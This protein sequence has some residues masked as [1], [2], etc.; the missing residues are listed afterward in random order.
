[1]KKSKVL[2]IGGGFAGCASAHL[3]GMKDDFDV[4][5]IELSPV[6]GA[7]VR[8]YF[9]GGHPYTFGPRHFLTQKQWIFDYLNQYLPLR[10]CNEHQFVTYVE[11]DANFY[12]YPIHEDD[13][14]RMPDSNEIFSQL[15]KTNLELIKNSKNLEEYWINSVGNNLYNKFINDYSKK[16]WNVSDNT[17]IDDFGWSPKGATLK[18]GPRAA[19]D[20]AISAYPIALDGYNA[21][22]DIATAKAKVLLNTKIE[23]FDIEKKIVFFNGNEEKYDIIINTISPDI[24]FDFCFGELPYMGRDLIKL[25]L[26]VE[27]ALPKDVYFS[28]YA[29]EENFTRVVE[30]K[31]LSGFKSDSTLIGIEF[32]SNNG[33]HYPMPFLSEYDRAEKYFN[34]MPENVYSIGRAGSYR[35]QV[36]IDDCIEQAFGVVDKIL[37]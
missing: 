21:Y 11:K 36:D 37:K 23:R 5:L 32:P 16:M 15:S 17:K 24:L 27:F 9:M 10:R 28:Y 25:I 20:I 6:L 33:R 2:I 34:L 35:Y 30:Y 3:L 19:W 18:K 7:G 13:I 31:K 29:G 1:M 14:S 4:T 22:F 8:T 26:P 12:S